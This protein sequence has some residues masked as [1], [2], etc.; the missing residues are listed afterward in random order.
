FPL[1][2]L[3]LSTMAGVEVYP[4]GVNAP[5]I[6]GGGE[7]TCG[8]IVLWTEGGALGAVPSSWG[9]GFVRMGWDPWR[10]GRTYPWARV[11]GGSLIG[12]AV[13]LAGGWLALTR[14]FEP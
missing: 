11:L 2:S 12:N 3:P 10:E 4:G 1:E 9:A 7:S 6:F 5:P 8:V 13:G 14:C